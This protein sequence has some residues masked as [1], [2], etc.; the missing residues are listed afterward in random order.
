MWG[1]LVIKGNGGGGGVGVDGRGGVGSVIRNGV[2][3]FILFIKCSIYEV[4][5]I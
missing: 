5:R 1:F 2:G 4:M 3:M